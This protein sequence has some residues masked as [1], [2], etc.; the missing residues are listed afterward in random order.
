M[1]NVRKLTGREAPRKLKETILQPWVKVV[2]MW[3]MMKL[4]F[5]FG[6]SRE[7]FSHA[8]FYAN[9]VRQP[10]RARDFKEFN[11]LWKHYCK[12]LHLP[13]LSDFEVLKMFCSRKTIKIQNGSAKLE[14]LTYW[15]F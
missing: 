1:N 2:E 7:R 9:G 11:E 5:V 4:D 13:V 3:H 6:L 10:L 12:R 8:E 14:I 15:H